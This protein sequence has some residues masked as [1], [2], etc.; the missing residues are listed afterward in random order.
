MDNKE[1]N[2]ALDNMD[3]FNQKYNHYVSDDEETQIVPVPKFEKKEKIEDISSYSDESMR[4]E[5]DEA[6]DEYKEHIS[7]N[8]GNFFTKNKYRNTKIISLILVIVL[9]LTAGGVLVWLYVSTKSNGYGDDGVDYNKI[10]K[11]YLVDDDT[12]FKVMG[13]IDADSLNAFLYQ[14]ANNGGDKM[15]N[16]NVINVLLCGVDSEYNLC[17]SQILV[18]IDK[19]NEKI[20]MV[21]FLRDSWTYI[22]MPKEDG[23]YYDEYEKINAAYH[24][25]PKTLLETLENNYKI[26]I[27]Q[28]ICVDFKSFPKVIDAIGGVTVPVQDYEADYIR[29][30][31]SQTDFP[32]GTATLNGKQAL[33]YSRIRHCDDDND[34]SRTRRQRTVIKALISQAKEA[35]NGQLVNAFKQI[36]PYLR[37]G[38]SQSEVISLIATA[39]SHNWMNFEISEYI[40]PN[41]DYVE[42][43]GGMINSTTWAWTVDYPL[44]AQRLQKILYGKTNIVLSEDRISPLD[45]VSNRRDTTT[46][47]GSSSSSSS[48][49]GS[50]N[51]DNS[52]SSYDEP[53]VPQEPATEAPTDA[54]E[55]PVTEEPIPDEPA[56]DPTQAPEDEHNRFTLF[57]RNNGDE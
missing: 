39:Y 9:L 45:S 21:S 46:D 25:G 28:Y 53:Y 6:S 13:D 41:E 23:T 32:Y 15:S 24:G 47:S 29:R 17:D 27:D 35:S 22:K 11:N 34:L 56:E 3:E 31:S 5:N 10:D 7:D 44:C 1:R 18:S 49:S 50:Y 55:E 36:S 40:M 42:R 54:S 30:T 8:Q 16:K 52:N 20:T 57:D 2:D 4:D 37:T 19:K 26:K 48:D 51:D 14:W 38:Y 43:I 33:I 12:Q